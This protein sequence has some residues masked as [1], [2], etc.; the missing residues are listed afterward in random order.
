[1]H[2]WHRVMHRLGWHLCTLVNRRDG[3]YLRCERCGQEELYVSNKELLR[4]APKHTPHE[5]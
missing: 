4:Y 3:L 1:M 5:L 2:W